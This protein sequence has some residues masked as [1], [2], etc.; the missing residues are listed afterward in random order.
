MNN[1]RYRLLITIAASV[2][3][4]GCNNRE[5]D[6]IKKD[7]REATKYYKLSNKYKER[8]IRLLAEG[9][10]IT[11]DSFSKIADQYKWV[12]DSFDMELSKKEI[13]N[14]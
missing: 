13:L 10:R 4:F 5:E 11:S 3:L 8:A 1:K 14:Q 7:V 9:N 12:A 6:E 2:F